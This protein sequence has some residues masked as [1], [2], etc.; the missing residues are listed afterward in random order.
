MA[1]LVAEDATEERSVVD[2]MAEQDAVDVAVGF[3]N[4]RTTKAGLTLA[5]EV[6]EFVLTAFFGGDFD[7]FVDP[8]PNKPVSFRRLL[9]REDLLLPPSTIYTFVR[10]ARQLRE[11]PSDLAER[12]SL[13]HHRA[14]LPLKSSSQKTA[15][16]RQALAEGWSKA[17]L[18]RRVR[19]EQPKALRGRKPLPSFVKAANTVAR[20]LDDAIENGD[21]ALQQLRELDEPRLRETLG[22]LEK[23]LV[24]LQWLHATLEQALNEQ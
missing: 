22:Q 12:L 20:V 15:L 2:S 13:S 7:R 1:P 19:G 3:I 24:R 9:E 4:E 23:S 14:L 8:R 16:A 18:E 11:L 10:V 21:E 5:R 17:D 6:G